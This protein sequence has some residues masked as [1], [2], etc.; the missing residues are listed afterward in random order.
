MTLCGPESFGADP[1]NIKWTVIRGDTATLKVEFF[2]DDEKTY[3]DTTDWE[4]TVSAYDKKSD[5]I[6][7]LDVV[8]HNGYIDITAPSSITTNWGS[9]YST[10]SIAEL[11]FDVQIT[12][13][14]TTWTPVLGTISVLSD[15]TFGGV[16]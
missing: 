8:S 6:D 9:G 4:Y 1:V 12:I 5:I 14:T 2:E 13:G 16:L 11:L 7:E 10:G 3:F 15:V